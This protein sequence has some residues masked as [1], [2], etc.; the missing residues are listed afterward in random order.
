MKTQTKTY[1][2]DIDGT[3]CST[4]ILN[5]VNHEFNYKNAKP[6]YPMINKINKLYKQG[7]VIIFN[8]ARLWIDFDITRKWL[9]RYKVNYHT[10]VCGKPYGDVYIDD[11]AVNIKE[12]IENENK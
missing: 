11:K 7:N 6:I 9:K 1:V 12:F 10:L 3:I 4:K 8:T 2:I 5:L